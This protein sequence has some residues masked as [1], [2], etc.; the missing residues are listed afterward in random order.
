M[1][2]T[3]S[4]FE[5]GAKKLHTHFLASGSEQK[6]ARAAKLSPQA[7][8]IWL[9]KYIKV[10]PQAAPQIILSNLNLNFEENEPAIRF[11]DL[12]STI[13][14]ENCDITCARFYVVNCVSLQFKNCNIRWLHY[15]TCW[16][17]DQSDILFDAC[18]VRFDTSAS[19]FFKSQHSTVTMKNCTV[20]AQ[21]MYEMMRFD[22][23]KV[24]VCHNKFE[25]GNSQ[26]I[27]VCANCPSVKFC[28][29]TIHGT[30]LY[31]EAAVLTAVEHALVANNTIVG[32]TAA[33]FANCKKAVLYNNSVKQAYSLGM[34]QFFYSIWLTTNID[35]HCKATF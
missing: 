15:D 23:C 7:Q 26:S 3:N 21:G 12:S 18:Q 6:V 35:R 29:N 1:G 8:T 24:D 4:R 22:S 9:L 32:M 17:L 31:Q 16:Y 28:H 11:S 2:G 33:S 25:I 30:K 13:I 20:S 5:R 27:I 14:F 10:W 34:L 19:H